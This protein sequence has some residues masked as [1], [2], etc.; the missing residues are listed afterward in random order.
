[1]FPPV[2]ESPCEVAA[3]SPPLSLDC[4]L[5][6]ASVAEKGKGRG[7]SA[8]I[9][10]FLHGTTLPKPHPSLTQTS[11]QMSIYIII[12]IVLIISN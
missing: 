2:S 4:P 5:I 9:S 3:P 12:N 6:H 8:T 1:M 7:A 10:P 11:L